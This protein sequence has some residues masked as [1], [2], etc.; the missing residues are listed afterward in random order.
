M[1][2]FDSIAGGLAIPVLVVLALYLIF[3]PLK[4]AGDPDEPAP[5]EAIM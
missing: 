1:N 2:I 4:K 5:P 3:V